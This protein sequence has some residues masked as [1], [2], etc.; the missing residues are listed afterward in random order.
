[1]PL[2]HAGHKK[3]NLK[4]IYKPQGG[5]V[6]LIKI[7]GFISIDYNN[8]NNNNLNSDGHLQRREG[9]ESERKDSH[10]SSSTKGPGKKSLYTIKCKS[11]TDNKEAM[12]NTHIIQWSDGS[13]SLLI[14]ED[15]QNNVQFDL[16]IAN[17]PS[18]HDYLYARHS[19]EGS[20]EAIVKLSKKMNILPFDTHSIITGSKRY[21]SSKEHEPMALKLALTTE[22]S[23]VT[24]HHE[25]VKKEREKRKSTINTTIG[26]LKKKM[27]GPK[28]RKYEVEDLEEDYE[29]DEYDREFIDDEDMID[30]EYSDND[31]DYEGSDNERDNT[32][33]SSTKHRESS[34]KKIGD[35]DVS[36]R[37]NIA[38]IFDDD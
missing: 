24:K 34:S 3:I 35:G 15:H 7:P 10:D 31:Q 8:E 1:M 13:Y 23:E 4:R 18:L 27:A 11:S 20:L 28:T 5:N 25:P 37:R 17:N 6:Y 30:D 19:E 33:S 32:P 38:R 12:T 16:N 14:V 26:S 2:Q 21:L 22:R 9:E 29:E 36:S